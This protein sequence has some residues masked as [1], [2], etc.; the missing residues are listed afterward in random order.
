VAG[1]GSSEAPPRNATDVEQHDAQPVVPDDRLRLRLNANVMVQQGAVRQM[2]VVQREGHYVL[3]RQVNER[4]S[5][6][7]REGALAGSLHSAPRTNRQ[8]QTCITPA[9]VRSA[10]DEPLCL[11][12][13]CRPLAWRRGVLSNTGM[14]SQPS[15]LS[16]LGLPITGRSCGLPSAAAYL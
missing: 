4:E 10:G 5:E 15:V 9:V 16:K 11:R 8:M 7:L 14:P 2:G 13:R 1:H 3:A 6:A 12:R